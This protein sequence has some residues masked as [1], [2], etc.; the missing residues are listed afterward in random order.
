MNLYII[1]FL[2][3]FAL[4]AIVSFY[5]F[6]KKTLLNFSGNRHQKFTDSLHVPLMGGIIVFFAI[7]FFVPFFNTIEKIAFTL[8]LLLGLLSDLKHL[9]SAKIR[10]YLQFVIIILFLIIENLHLVNTKVF[11]LDLLLQNYFFSILFTAFCFLIIIN[12]S[13]FLDGINILVIGYYLSITIII[14]ILQEKN[15]IFLDNISILNIII[16]LLVLFFFN[17][18]NKLYL[19]DNGSY[20]LGFIFSI[21]LVKFY[22]NNTF[23]SPFFIILLLWYPGFENLFS[24]FRRYFGKKS[25]VKPDTR[26]LHQLIY[27]YLRKYSFFQKKILINNFPGF[28]IITYNFFIMFLSCFFIYDSKILLLFIFLNISLY[29]LIYNFLLKSH[30]LQY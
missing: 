2:I 28:L 22:V 13:N 26:H 17:L 18:F 8:I 4:T 14:F 1:N 15:F 27:D 16:T 20:L 9:S 10:L 6:K 3:I 25:V 29:C 24:I 23:V 7:I 30:E 5:F 12:G 21:I 11:F 19:G